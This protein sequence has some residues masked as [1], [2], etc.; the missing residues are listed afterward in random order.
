MV[1]DHVSGKP[2]VAASQL[3]EVFPLIY[4]HKENSIENSM[5][6]SSVAQYLDFEHYTPFRPPS[7]F[8]FAITDLGR[9]KGI[10]NPDRGPVTGLNP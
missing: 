8:T 9:I 10:N 5:L 7:Y 1:P 6:T 4:L 3:A 2:G